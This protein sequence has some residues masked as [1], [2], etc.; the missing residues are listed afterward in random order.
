MAMPFAVPQMSEEEIRMP[1]QIR[2]RLRCMTHISSMR[3]IGDSLPYWKV[4]AVREK[5]WS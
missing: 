4:L 5:R 1:L 3:K 2:Q